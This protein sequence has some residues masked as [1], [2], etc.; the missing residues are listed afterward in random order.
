[1]SPQG[2]GVTTTNAGLAQ[3]MKEPKGERQKKILAVLNETKRLTENL[4]NYLKA[5]D[6]KGVFGELR[7][8]KK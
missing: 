4:E 8:P 2:F 5:L 1:M 3:L 7:Q 6:Q